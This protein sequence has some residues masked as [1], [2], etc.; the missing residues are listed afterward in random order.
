LSIAKLIERV[1]E[2]PAL[3]STHTRIARLVEREETTA[4]EL[5]RV[6][7]EDQGLTIRILRASNNVSRFRAGQ[8]TTVSRAIISLG[9]RAV[10]AT[11]LGAS[12]MTSLRNYI[13]PG[14]MNCWRHGYAVGS[15]CRCIATKCRAT[16][17]EEAFVLGLLHDMGRLVLCLHYPDVYQTIESR[18]A[19]ESA[20]KLGLVQLEDE[21]LGVSH[22]EVSY[23]LARRWKLPE[24][25]V[26]VARHHHLPK[27][28]GPFRA[29]AACVHLADT[30]ANAL[31]LGD[32]GEPYLSAL[33]FEDEDWDALGIRS[34]SELEP[35]M[36]EALFQFR[37]FDGFLRLTRKSTEAT[38]GDSL[39]R[40]RAVTP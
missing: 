22:A 11:V 9:F 25:I 40:V 16:D 23:M 35:V 4:D 13:T 24:S 14:L 33:A 36:I 31:A 27:G 6:I 32:E 8:I 7:S 19:A 5:A 20:V 37:E 12:V 10:K 1:E 15:I 34:A 21:L 3:P 18:L 38:V 17:P 30:L 28:A 39:R 26:Q 2:L 29:E